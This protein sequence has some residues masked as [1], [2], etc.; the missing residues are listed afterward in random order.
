M[1]IAAIVMSPSAGTDTSAATEPIQ[2]RVGL[3]GRIA[4]SIQASRERAAARE[5]KRYIDLNGGVLTDTLE[6][7]ISRRYGTLVD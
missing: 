5:I 1:S 6:R 2:E 4:S 3:F 7:E